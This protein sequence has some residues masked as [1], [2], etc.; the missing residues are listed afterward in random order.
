MKK[1]PF[2]DCT[3][4]DMNSTAEFFKIVKNYLKMIKLI[5]K[6]NDSTNNR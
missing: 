6:N 5:T 1:K 2:K 4:G 3:I